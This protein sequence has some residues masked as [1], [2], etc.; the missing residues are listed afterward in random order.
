MRY[1]FYGATSFNNGEDAGTSAPLN[2]NVG[3][4]TDMSG[5]FKDAESFNRANAHW[6][7]VYT[8]VS[9]SD[10]DY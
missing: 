10:E 3:N 7:P 5:M 9:A 1:M 8:Y 6:A 2:W 4:V